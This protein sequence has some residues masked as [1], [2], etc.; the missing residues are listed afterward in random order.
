[1]NIQ[2]LLTQA[3]QS[4]NLQNISD[5]TNTP[6]D[7]TEQ[8]IKL[9]GPLLIGALANNTKTDQG[10]QALHQAVKTK[11][12][13]TT[14]NGDLSTILQ[15]VDMQD[16]AKILGHIFGSQ[17]E[18][19]TQKVAQK[20]GVDS[21]QATNILSVLAPMILGNLGSQVE[22]QNQTPDDLATTVQQ[23]ASGFDLNS[24]ATSLLDQNHDG[25]IVDDLASMAL[26]KLFGSQ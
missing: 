1:M 18:Q 7:A 6:P 19:V 21:T 14:A 26:K 8:I 20:A 3:T 11:H 10:K 17:Q 24:L 22:S 12:T 9:A 2:Q 16:G 23:Q 15:N 4:D 25:S 5:K 13:K